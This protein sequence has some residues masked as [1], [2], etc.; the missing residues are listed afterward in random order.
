[1]NINKQ[2][3][4][5]YVNTYQIQNYPVKGTLILNQIV[6]NGLDYVFNK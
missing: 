2:N 5:D 1:M 4:L 3:Y 6:M